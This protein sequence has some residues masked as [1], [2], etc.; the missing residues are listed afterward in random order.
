MAST[1][2]LIPYKN[3]D[4]PI[5]EFAR[6]LIGMMIFNK[7]P[8][9]QEYVH[10]AYEVASIAGDAMHTSTG[11]EHDH[12]EVEDELKGLHRHG[13]L[14]LQKDT[15][16]MTDDMLKLAEYTLSRELD[17]DEGQATR[18]QH[19]SPTADWCMVSN[20]RTLW[21][22]DVLEAWLNQLFED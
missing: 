9:L 20:G 10:S 17:A 22:M 21:T 19:D 15:T 12:N 2:T 3:R 4:V 8:H 14:Q 5:P 16:A 1:S 11:P 13:F 18:R 6:L 7:F